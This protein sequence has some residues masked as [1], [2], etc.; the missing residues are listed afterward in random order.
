MWQ[1][2]KG[3]GTKAVVPNRST[4]K[5]PFSFDK[6]SYT[7][8][9]RIEN[10]FCWLKDL[11]C[12]A[13]RDDRLAGKKLPRLHLARGRYRMVDFISLDPNLDR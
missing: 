12:I 10:A 8:P 9:H 7:Q 3:R 13:T 1:W 11:R 5:Q 2:L 4:R 6:K